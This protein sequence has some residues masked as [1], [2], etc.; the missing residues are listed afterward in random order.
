MFKIYAT[1]AQPQLPIPRTAN[2]LNILRWMTN[3]LHL[4]Y[5][6]VDYLII[7][8][9]ICC[10]EF[11]LYIV[12]NVTRALICC[13]VFVTLVHLCLPIAQWVCWWAVTSCELLFCVRQLFEMV[14]S[15]YSPRHITLWIK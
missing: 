4:T 8:P 2:T 9:W 15:K 1:L 3:H 14:A 12:M 10:S 11:V 13:D 5:C 6:M 7:C